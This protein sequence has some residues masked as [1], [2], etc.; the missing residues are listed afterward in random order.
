[1]KRPTA[2]FALALTLTL[3]L[4][5]TANAA[6]LPKAVPG[7][8]TVDT[9]QAKQLLDKGATFVDLRNSRKWRAGHVP[10]AIHLE[11]RKVFSEA[12]LGQHVGKEQAVAFYM[13]RC[14]RCAKAVEQAVAWGYTNVYFFRD[15]MRGWAKQGFPVESGGQ[16]GGTADASR[17]GKKARKQQPAETPQI[18]RAHV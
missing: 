13:D 14:G 12:A 17:Q 7:A 6:K 5:A 11:F 18:G 10:G 1:M 9:Q 3:A 16:A 15:G 8:Q 2:C 4:A